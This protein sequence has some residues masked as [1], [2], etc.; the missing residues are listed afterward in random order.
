MPSTSLTEV[1]F[2]IMINVLFISNYFFVRKL[3]RIVDERASEKEN[4]ILNKLH[5]NYAENRFVVGFK[6]FLKGYERAANE[7]DK[8]K[9][10]KGALVEVVYA[11]VLG[12][13][14]MEPSIEKGFPHWHRIPFKLNILSTSAA[15]LLATFLMSSK[16]PLLTRFVVSTEN[17]SS[18]GFCETEDFVEKNNLFHDHIF[19][20]NVTNIDLG[21]AQTDRV[22]DFHSAL[23]KATTR[24][25]IGGFSCPSLASN[26]FTGTKQS[27]EDYETNLIEFGPFFPGYCAA[28][29][30]Y[31][32]LNGCGKIPKKVCLDSWGFSWF[33]K[34]I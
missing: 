16:N 2:L 29:R 19:G 34:T 1:G 3:R 23:R 28:A 32:Q 13:H 33:C 24:Y 5:R 7:G 14:R 31:I 8:G 18:S 4:T 17:G 12:R 11:F 15:L 10:K 25:G 22:L 6:G 21:K 20:E 26:P 27:Y 9:I 30:D